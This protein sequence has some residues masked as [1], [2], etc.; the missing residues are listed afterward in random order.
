MHFEKVVYEKNGASFAVVEG[1]RR[2]IIV[3]SV[4]KHEGEVK[5]IHFSLRPDGLVQYKQLAKFTALLSEGEQPKFCAEAF[6]SQR[7]SKKERRM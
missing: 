3:W 5:L 1:Q 6:G 4:A 2:P 7:I